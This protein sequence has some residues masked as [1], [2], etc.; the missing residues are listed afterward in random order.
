MTIPLNATLADLREAR[1][2]L[3]QKM[4]ADLIRFD[5][6]AVKA[7]SL[8]S[9]VGAGYDPIQIWMLI[10]EVRAV[11]HQEVIAKEMSES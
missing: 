6:L 11:A 5:A 2:D 8:R 7:D 4:A 3:I 1:Q 9:L 10:D